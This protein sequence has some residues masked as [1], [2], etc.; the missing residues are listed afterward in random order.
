MRA[1]GALRVSLLSDAGQVMV[2]RKYLSWDGFFA[3]HAVQ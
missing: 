1:F 2:F 3:W